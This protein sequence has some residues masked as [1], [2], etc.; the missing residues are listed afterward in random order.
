MNLAPTDIA[1]EEI[2]GCGFFYG[3]APGIES[4]N[5]VV[6]GVARTDIPV[7]LIGES[8]TGKDAYAR[9]IHRLYSGGRAEGFRKLSC[10]I[11]APGALREAFQSMGHENGEETR[12][13]LF[14]DG[15]HDLDL[16]CQRILLTLLPDSDPGRGESRQNLRLISST[17]N[18]LKSE[19]RAGR[20]LRELYFRI[21]GV[22]VQLPALRDRGKDVGGFLRFFLQKNAQE[23]KKGIPLLN[24]DAEGI[25]L[26]YDWPGNIREL[27]N[28]ARSMVAIG[29]P[30]LALD[31]LCASSIE[32]ENTVQEGTEISL[33]VA[34]REATRRT[35]RVL[36]LK[37]LERRHWNRKRAASD[38]KVSYKSLLYKIKQIGMEKADWDRTHGEKVT[39]A[40]E[41]M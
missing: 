34:T 33:K 41:K 1:N 6:A 3:D 5:R 18:G 26:S 32:E 8:G 7:L 37:A 19:I 9:L 40:R 29:S 20:F 25:L 39:K 12:Q 24:A 31:R 2:P 28:V 15:I 21:S 13:T 22:S 17:S 36:I 38:L 30:I 10:G 23:L 16:A 14:L 4:V 11:Q 27:E 35:E